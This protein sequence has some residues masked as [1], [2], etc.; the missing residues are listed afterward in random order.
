M[1]SKVTADQIRGREC[2]CG[3]D[4]RAQ[5]EMVASRTI[6]NSRGILYRRLQCSACGEKITTVELHSSVL[7]L[8]EKASLDETQCHDADL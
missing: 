3:N 5:F 2:E 6:A 8:F 1:L 4:I 7:D